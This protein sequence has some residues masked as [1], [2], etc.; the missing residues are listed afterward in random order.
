MSTPALCPDGREIVAR[1]LDLGEVALGKLPEAVTDEERHAGAQVSE[2]LENHAGE[3]ANCGRVVAGAFLDG[4][5]MAL[6]R[7]DTKA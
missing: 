7:T 6:E 5:R 4:L 1:M 2:D 3:C